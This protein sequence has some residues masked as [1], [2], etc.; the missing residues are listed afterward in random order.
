MSP[1]GFQEGIVRLVRRGGGADVHEDRARRARAGELG[2]LEDPERPRSRAVAERSGDEPP[3]VGGEDGVGVV[4]AHALGE[5]RHVLR[6]VEVDGP[7]RVAAPV[8]DGDRVGV[9]GRVTVA[10]PVVVRAIDEGV[11]LRAVRINRPQAEARHVG[12]LLVVRREGGVAEIDRAHDQAVGLR[13][14]VEEVERAVEATIDERA[15]GEGGVEHLAAVRRD[16][17]LERGLVGEVQG[18]Q[19]VAVRAHGVDA[20]VR[21]L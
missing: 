21:A 16:G 19:L 5:E 7:E 6:S 18:V 17:R 9:E 1:F 20:S 11:I 14:E 4:K 15:A 3:I 10:E 13:G 2:V 12:H 8:D